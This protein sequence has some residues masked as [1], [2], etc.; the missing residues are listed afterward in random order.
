MGCPPRSCDGQVINEVYS[1][2]SQV[3]ALASLV[4]QKVFHVL[5]ECS[6]FQHQTYS[7]TATALCETRR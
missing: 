6:D 2:F 5:L 3:A 7:N 4:V 1:H